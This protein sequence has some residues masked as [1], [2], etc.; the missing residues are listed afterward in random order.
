MFRDKDV[1]DFMAR[2]KSFECSDYYDA[3]H[4]ECIEEDIM[5]EYADE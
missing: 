1:E 3:I 2:R 4:D 5:R